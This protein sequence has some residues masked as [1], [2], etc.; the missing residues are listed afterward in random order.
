MTINKYIFILKNLTFIFAIIFATSS[1]AQFDQG[2]WIFGA[3]DM[4]STASSDGYA[5]D[6]SYFVADGVMV[7]LTLS[8]NTSVGEEDD[9]FFYVKVIWI[10][11]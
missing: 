2:T 4:L 1:F 7:S 5:V 10:G 9:D 6:V 3:G 8:G 11:L